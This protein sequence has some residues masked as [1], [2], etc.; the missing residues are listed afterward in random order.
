MGLRFLPKS[1]FKTDLAHGTFEKITITFYAYCLCISNVTQFCLTQHLLKC[2][3][4]FL[5]FA[6]GVCVCV[7]GGGVTTKPHLKTT[8][9]LPL[10]RY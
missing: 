5:M 10:P 7:C 3:V 9:K 6:G 4:A 2:Y 1:V 8:L